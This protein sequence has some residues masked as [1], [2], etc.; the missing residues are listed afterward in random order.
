[1]FIWC[2]K[3]YVLLYL[4]HWDTSL[5]SMAFIDGLFSRIR[6]LGMAS[7]RG[8][9]AFGCWRKKKKWLKLG[10]FEKKNYLKWNQILASGII[11]NAGVYNRFWSTYI[12]RS[13]WHRWIGRGG[14]VAGGHVFAATRIHPFHFSMISVWGC[15]WIIVEVARMPPWNWWCRVCKAKQNNECYKE[16]VVCKSEREKKKYWSKIYIVNFMCF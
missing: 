9:R 14:L 7:R 2:R 3:L 10:F 1:M 13:Q 4:N 16:R 15:E 12:P 6:K 11:I 5:V 8:F